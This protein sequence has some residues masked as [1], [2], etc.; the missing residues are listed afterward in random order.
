ME[1]QRRP[2]SSGARGSQKVWHPGLSHHRNRAGSLKARLSRNT[3]WRTCRVWGPLPVSLR[4][5]RVRG[6]AHV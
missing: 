4:L 5:S 2:A 1:P 3:G 6:C